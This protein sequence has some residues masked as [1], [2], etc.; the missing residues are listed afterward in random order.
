MNESVLLG[1][2][3]LSTIALIASYAVLEMSCLLQVT[4]MGCL[5]PGKTNS[6]VSGLCSIFR[7]DTSRSLVNES[8]A[9]RYVFG[10]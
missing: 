1:M 10:T 7:S 4:S 2:K 6:L 3:A 9:V 8:A 5:L